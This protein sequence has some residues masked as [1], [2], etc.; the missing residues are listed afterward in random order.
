MSTL[1]RGPVAALLC[2]IVAFAAALAW[3]V[4]ARLSYFWIDLLPHLPDVH[5]ETMADALGRVMP[6]PLYFPVSARTGEGMDRW[7]EWLENPRSVQHA[8]ESA[9]RVW[10]TA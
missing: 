10:T 8:R 3:S 9:R 1:R 7:P 5:L 2:S 6:R 4:W